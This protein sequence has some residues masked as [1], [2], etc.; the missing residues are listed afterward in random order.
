[1]PAVWPATL[2]QLPE[3]NWVERKLENR[4]KS[5]T[6]TGPAKYRR[7][8]TRANRQVSLSMFLTAAQVTTLDIFHTTTLSDGVLK[9]EMVHPRTG[10]THEFRF[11]STFEVVEIAEGLYKTN[12]ELEYNV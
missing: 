7:R 9:F 8:F 2:P 12:I 4:V 6:E 3:Y 10:L 11:V 5:E 1:M